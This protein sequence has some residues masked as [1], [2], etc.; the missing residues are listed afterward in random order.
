MII[1]KR[2]SGVQGAFPLYLEGV[3]IGNGIHVLIDSGSTHNVI[4][5]NIVRTIGL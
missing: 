4:D 3:I 5:I 2:N 1:G